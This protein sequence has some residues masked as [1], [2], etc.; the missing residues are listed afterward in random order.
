MSRH[1]RPQLLA[2]AARLNAELLARLGGEL[3]ASRKRRR[4]TQATLGAMIGVSQST[5]SL[6]ECGR[7]GSLSLDVW[8]RA[9]VALDRPLRLDMPRDRL[10]QPAD[11]GHL[12]VQE[13]VLRMARA[14]GFRSTFELPTRPMDPGRSADVGLRHDAH[15]ILAL[16]ECWNLMGDVGAAARSTNRKLAEAAELAIVLGGERPYRVAGCWVVRAT[17]RNRDLVDRYPEVFAARF[18]GSSVAWVRAIST[19]SEPPSEP[20]LVWCDV[21]GTRL[22]PWRR[23]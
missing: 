22:F 20:G 18:P 17:R 14:V 13:L 10:E 7:G 11:A 8:Q 9:F 23:R 19:G 4:V 21:A 16:T 2:E 6:M 15:R 3:R 1:R 12:L 5:I